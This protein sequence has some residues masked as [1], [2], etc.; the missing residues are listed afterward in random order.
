MTDL[1]TGQAPRPSTPV[2]GVWRVVAPA[3]VPVRV[4]ALPPAPTADE[5]SE[6]VPA[7]SG[8]GPAAAGPSNSLAP[9]AP[10]SA[11]ALPAPP[12]SRARTPTPQPPT[13]AAAPHALV[14]ALR[15]DPLERAWLALNSGGMDGLSDPASAARALLDTPCAVVRPAEAGRTRE[16]WVF[17]EGELVLDGLS[18]TPEPP[19]PITIEATVT[20][21]E[22]GHALACLSPSCTCSPTFT[23]PETWPVFQAAVGE[24]LAWR[25]GSRLSLLA[26]EAS[27]AATPPFDVSLTPVPGALLLTARPRALVHCAPRPIGAAFKPGREA[28]IEPYVLSPL[29]LP[30]LLLAPHH[31][32]AAQDAR[33]AAA[34]DNALGGGWRAGRTEARIAAQAAGHRP[35]PDWAVYFVP[36]EQRPAPAV[37]ERMTPLPVATRWRGAHGVLTVWPTHLTRPLA[38]ERIA[39]T[40]PPQPGPGLGTPS[41]L[42][43]FAVGAFDVLTNYIEPPSDDSP[44]DDENE[45]PGDEVA[46]DTSSKREEEGEGASEVDDLFSSHSD[47]PVPPSM[48]DVDMADGESQMP[49]DATN[50]G[51]DAMDEDAKELFSQSVFSTPRAAAAADEGD[52]DLFGSDNGDAAAGEAGLV[53]PPR[54]PSTRG[55]SRGASETAEVAITEDDFNFFDSPAVETVGLEVVHEGKVEDEPTP[56]AE[57]GA[58]AAVEALE[59]QEPEGKPEPPAELS[60]TFA[61]E[62]EES[63]PPK[64][65]E[66]E[67]IQVDAAPEPEPEREADP[68]PPK[69]ARV[70]VDMVPPEFAPLSLGK[71]RRARFAYGL[72]SPS[73]PVDNLRIELVERLRASQKPEKYNYSTGWDLDSDESDT[74]DDSAFTTGAPPTPTSDTMGDDGTPAPRQSSDAPPGPVADDEVEFD[75]TVCVGS[76]WT[77]LKDDMSAAETLARAWNPVWVDIGLELPSIYPPSPRSP[78]TQLDSDFLGTLNIEALA[79]A[80]VRNRFFRSVFDADTAAHAPVRPPGPLVKSGVS[81]SEL[82]EA[83]APD[84]ESKFPSYGLPNAFVNVGYGSSIMRIGAAALRYWRELGLSPGGGPKAIKAF[85]VCEPGDDATAVAKDFLRDI[86][87]T[88]ESYNL[89]THTAG[90][91]ELA[92]DGVVAIAPSAIADATV[93]IRARA[94]SPTVVYIISYNQS[95]SVSALA[96]LLGS[97]SNTSWLYVVPAWSISVGNL[98]GMAFEVYDL[99]PREIRRVTPHGKPLAALAAW[100]P[101]HAFTLSPDPPPKPQLSMAWPQRSFDVLNR[102]RLV[103]GAYTFIPSLDVLLVA[104][105]DTNGDACTIRALRLDGKG[106]ARERVAAA[107]DV[108]AQFAAMAATEWRLVICSYGI[109]PRDELDAWR[110]LASG[111]QT[112]LSIVMVDPPAPNDGPVRSRPAVANIPPSTFGDPSATIVD[113]TLAG[114]SVALSYRPP[115]EIAASAK[116]EGAPSTMFPLSSF[117]VGVAT[118]AGTS[119]ASSVYHVVFDRPLPNATA[120]PHAL[121]APEFH[122]LTC[123]GRRRYGLDGSLPVHLESV[124]AARRALEAIVANTPAPPEPTPAKV[125]TPAPVPAVEKV[126]SVEDLARQVSPVVAAVAAAV[127]GTPAPP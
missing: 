111:R 99:V 62:V 61:E 35:Q 7:E 34:F 117:V 76:E 13:T 115:V 31:A 8:E 124:G 116:G 118:P 45:L 112:P 33:L 108:F 83:R 18:E 37:L 41:D 71:R 92:T 51:E 17:G 86:S 100:M 119:T 101:Y 73:S 27:V 90:E 96:P 97:A 66:P 5:G 80:V 54:E 53:V 36:L 64:V 9:A 21:P 39:P 6:P 60:V 94:T 1:L 85:V 105:V 55:P 110:T 59:I 125:P 24:K 87:E 50:A 43:G 91:D 44:E 98:P 69:K 26:P 67:V 48:A 122:R 19:T 57:A 32:T 126:V 15:A 68:R 12:A 82:A 63:E 81:L 75:G 79:N 109:M 3:V 11:L 120:D 52:D 42:L 25:L 123:L 95:L 70:S 56:K 49:D 29:A 104:V 121:L 74:E 4:Y 103:H 107:W 58:E 84:A 14:G 77:S 40:R 88:Y 72:P 78:R 20:C 2:P 65:D 127:V 114:S 30:A 89:G 23:P 106:T 93:K 22:H 10:S 16:L 28:G 113:E 47:S 38:P 46:D 102:W